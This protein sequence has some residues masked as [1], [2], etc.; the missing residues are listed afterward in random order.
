MRWLTCSSCAFRKSA[1]V[2]KMVENLSPRRCGTEPQLVEQRRPISSLICRRSM[3]KAKALMPGSA[4]SRW[5]ASYSKTCV[6]LEFWHRNGVSTTTQLGRT[7]LWAA[8]SLTNET[9]FPPDPPRN[10]NHV[11][12][13]HGGRTGRLKLQLQIAPA[14]VNCELRYWSIK[15]NQCSVKHGNCSSR[16][17]YSDRRHF[18]YK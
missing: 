4:T 6:K 17:I 15:I 11:G 12:S 8:A 14:S 5:M 10:N 13:Q 1:F 3:D 7:A 18:E 16:M 9:T 2:L